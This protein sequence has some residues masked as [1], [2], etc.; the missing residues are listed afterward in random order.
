MSARTNR[1]PRNLPPV[2]VLAMLALVVALTGTATAGGVARGK[3][4]SV[5]KRLNDGE[6]AGNSIDGSWVV[7]VT[8]VNP[9]A[10]VPPT[11]KSLMTFDRGGG[12]TETSNTGTTLRSP[13]HGV[14]ER[15]DGRAYATTM[16]FFGFNP[17]T[18]AFLG[19]QRVNRTM[20]LSQDGQ[21]FEA[22]SLA[23][24]YDADDILTIGGLHATESG[25]RISVERIA[26]QP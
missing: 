11:F 18:G 19:T 5:Q 6:A 2:M 15:I 3:S 22:V 14:W 13:A 12:L 1:L 26:D 23:A 16:V 20:R 21:T 9:P 7:T 4:K 10:N 25:E 8:R 17:Q 24:Q